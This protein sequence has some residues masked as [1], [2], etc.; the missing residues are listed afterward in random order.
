MRGASRSRT[1]RSRRSRTSR[2]TRFERRAPRATRSS[3]STMTSSAARPAFVPRPRSA[4]GLHRGAAARWSTSAARL[5]RGTREAP[6]ALACLLAMNLT[7]RDRLGLSLLSLDGLSVG[8]A[9]GNQGLER[10]ASPPWTWTDDT[11]MALAIVECLARDGSLDADRLAAACVRGFDADRGRG[12][13]AGTYAILAA[14]SGGRPWRELAGAVFGGEGSRGNGAAMRAAPIGAYFYDDYE[15][16]AREART[17]AAPTHAHPDGEAGAVAVAL[18]AAVATRIGKDAR[19]PREDVLRV[20]LAHLDPGPTRDWLEKIAAVPFTEDPARVATIFG[21]G[22]Q[23]LS[24][25]TV[26]FCLWC[27]A[28]HLDSYEDAVW[29]AIDRGGDPDTTGA[30]VGG[31]VA[32]AVGGPPAAWKEATEPVRLGDDERRAA[33]AH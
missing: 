25:D 21:D 19:L 27:A 23:I 33:S 9:L 14:A 24:S 31:I 11:A 20:P 8:D 12:Y 28:R 26:P 30:I 32:L 15:R 4:A 7:D 2:S 3:I 17:S 6:P 16:V 22:S 13:G 1:P 5:S 18:A 29:T 10:A